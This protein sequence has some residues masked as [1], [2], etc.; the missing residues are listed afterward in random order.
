[1]MSI[2]CFIKCVYLKKICIQDQTLSSV[3]QVMSDYCKGDKTEDDVLKATI[4]YEKHKI[5][6]KI[7][8]QKY[9][10]F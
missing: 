7:I 6:Q 5:E 1:M 8:K 10:I 3:Y 9:F 4:D 2:S